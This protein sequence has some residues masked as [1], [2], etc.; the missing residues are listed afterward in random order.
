MSI[1][2]GTVDLTKDFARPIAV[3][4]AAYSSE[5][6]QRVW[7]DPG[8]DWQMSF[9]RFRFTVGEVDICRFGPRGGQQYIN[10]NR[11]LAIEREKRIVC[12]TSLRSNGRLNFAGTLVVTFE[13]GHGGTRLRIIEQGLYFDGEDGVE[14]HRSGWQ[15]ML[16]ALGEYLTTDRR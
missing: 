14:G 10:E 2:E 7:S 3:V 11:Y 6:A 12:S 15:S 8:D 4:F 16:N 1:V 9:D 5:E 13:P